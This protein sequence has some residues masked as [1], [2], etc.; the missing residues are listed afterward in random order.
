MTARPT[1]PVTSPR[2]SPGASRVTAEVRAEMTVCL[3][4][5]QTL[6]EG[7]QAERDRLLVEVMERRRSWLGRLV[8]QLRV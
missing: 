6:L 4:L 1:T 5:G 2:P 3:D 8:G 7:V